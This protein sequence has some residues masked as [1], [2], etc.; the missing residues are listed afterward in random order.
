[1]DSGK[2]G[3]GRLLVYVNDECY[4]PKDMFI[5]THILSVFVH[6]ISLLNFHMVV[7]AVYVTHRNVAKE[8]VKEI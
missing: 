8:A 7:M 6:V 3:G 1:M 5:K 2:R 4:H